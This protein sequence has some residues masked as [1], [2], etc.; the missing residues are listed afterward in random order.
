MNPLTSVP[1]QIIAGDSYEI[2]LGYTDYPSTTWTGNLLLRGPASASVTATATGTDFL[3][4]LATTDTNIASGSYAYAVQVS[5]GSARH[6]VAQG[7]T[8]VLVN[9]ASAT[10]NTSHQ[11]TMIA[12]IEAVL[13]GRIDDGTDSISI[14]GRSLSYIPLPELRELRAAYYKELA[15]IKGNPAMTARKV[16]PITFPGYYA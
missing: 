4:T 11:E 7:Y 13:E 9:L 10:T 6:T 14:N 15:A 16:I 1:A 8:T 5:S 3:F 12:A 2:K